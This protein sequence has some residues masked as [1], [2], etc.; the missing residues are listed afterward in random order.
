MLVD[1][2]GLLLA[3]LAMVLVPG[4]AWSPWL[5]LRFSEMDLIQKF[6]ISLGVGFALVTTSLFFLNAAFA[7]PLDLWSILA[8]VAGLS[9]PLLLRLI[10][11]PRRDS[12]VRRLIH[13]WRRLERWG[14]R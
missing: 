1:F 7:L 2:V 11:R 4:L 5:V 9:S 12:A 3:L 10:P 6:A 14:P 13:L 8:V